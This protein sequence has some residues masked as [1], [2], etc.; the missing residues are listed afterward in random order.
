MSRHK[1][2]IHMTGPGC[3]TVKVDG[4]VM[5]CSEATF[6][7][8]VG[9]VNEV[10][11]RIIAGEVVIIADANLRASLEALGAVEGKPL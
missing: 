3:G 9:E 5:D 4:V 10:T 8:A 6:H 2:E 7:A 11:L 1:V